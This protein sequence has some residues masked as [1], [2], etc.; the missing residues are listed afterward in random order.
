MTSQKQIDANRRNA[1]EST[2]PRTAAGKSIV[3]T[4]AFKHGIFAESPTIIGENT[5]AFAT[6]KQSLLDPQAALLKAVAATV[7]ETAPDPIRHP[8]PPPE[9]T[10][11]PPSPEPLAAENGSVSANSISAA[12]AHFLRPDPRPIPGRP[13]AA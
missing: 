7:L 1:Q 2:G 12:R 3:A 8:A 13:D 5:S 6:L 4:N 11:Q 9:P 10:S